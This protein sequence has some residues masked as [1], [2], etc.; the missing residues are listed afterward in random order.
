MLLIFIL[1][2]IVIFIVIVFFAFPQFS[3]IPY[4]PSNGKDMGLIVDALELKNDQTVIDLGAGDGAVVFAAAGDAYKRKLK[5][6]FIA[7][8]INPV[9]I[10]IMYIKWFFHPNRRNIKII[11][12]NIFSIDVKKLITPYPPLA[13]IYLY[14][15]PWYL[16]MVIKNLKFQIKNFS[17]ISYMYP[18]KS[19]KKMEKIIKGL[20]HNIF[21]YNVINV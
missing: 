10:L 6:Q 9:L 21:R 13:A 4:F 12:G 3:P 15:S 7:I 2:V 1:L 8:D 11:R 5:T 16:E 20:K 14:I 17:V 19:L 18:I